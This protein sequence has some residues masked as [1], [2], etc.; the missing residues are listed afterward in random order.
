MTFAAKFAG[1]C[2]GE[3]DGIQPGDEV[4]F[5]GLMVVHADCENIHGRIEHPETPTCT[6]CWLQMPC[7]CEDDQ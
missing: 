1:P 4:E 7:P 5:N 6:S 2:P 3:C